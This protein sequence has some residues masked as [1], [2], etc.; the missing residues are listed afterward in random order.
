MQEVTILLCSAFSNGTLGCM[1]HNSGLDQDKRTSTTEAFINDVPAEDSEDI[2]LD[3]DQRS[4]PL[5]PVCCFDILYMVGH[6][7]FFSSS[8]QLKS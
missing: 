2:S 3:L 7:Y 4:G 5:P 6:K 8:V 1:N